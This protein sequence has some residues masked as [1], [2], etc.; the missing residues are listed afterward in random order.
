MFI[1]MDIS[2]I[3]LFNLFMILGIG[4]ALFLIK[5]AKK[6]SKL[7]HERNARERRRMEKLY[8]GVEHHALP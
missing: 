6:S 7:Q 8:G 1:T 2:G 3:T 4:L 5:D